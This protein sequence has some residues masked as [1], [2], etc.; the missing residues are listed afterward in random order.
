MVLYL[1][2]TEVHERLNEGLKKSAARAGEFVTAKDK[3]R[4]KVLVEF[5]EGIKTAAGSAHA[6]AH[7][8][9]NPKWLD[10]RD[11]LENII[12][13]GEGIPVFEEAANP[14]WIRIQTNINEL[15]ETCKKIYTMKAMKRQDVLAHLDFRGKNL[16]D[17]SQ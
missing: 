7:Y 14:I 10:I 4:P 1:S 12:T 3:Q 8:Q 16:P 11:I 5:V 17:T 6:L 9:A 13:I 2:E 15:L